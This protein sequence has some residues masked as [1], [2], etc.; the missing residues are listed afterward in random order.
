VLAQYADAK[1]SASEALPN[2]GYDLFTNGNAATRY[3]LDGG[4]FN[5]FGSPTGLDTFIGSVPHTNG[6]VGSRAFRFREAI[7]LSTDAARFYCTAIHILWCGRNGMRDSA[8]GP[9]YHRWFF[10]INWT[11]DVSKFVPSQ[12]RIYIKRGEESLDPQ[13]PAHEMGH[14]IDFFSRDDFEQ[15]FEGQEVNEALAEMF[16]FVVRGGL[17]LPDGVVGCSIFSLM[18]GGSI[19][20]IAGLA[21]PS[22]YSGYNCSTSDEHLNGYILGHAF[23]LMENAIGAGNAR[24][25]LM[26]VPRLLPARREFGDVHQAFEDATDVTGR[27]ELRDA[28]HKAFIDAGVTTSKR[29]TDT[30]PGASA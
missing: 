18:Q 12:Q 21:I 4:F 16:D 10:T 13:T 14:E 19:C 3:D 7:D 6:T 22:H 23:F 20:T 24:A 17:P 5:T 1:G 28:V 9:G 30:C 8:L 27:P 26:E 15:T 11:G 25:L 2:D 29:R